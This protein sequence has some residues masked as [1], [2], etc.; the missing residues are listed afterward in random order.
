ME[1]EIEDNKFFAAIGYLG[2]LCL[3]PLLLAKDSKF[4]QHHGKQG[5]VILLAWILL[6]VGNIIPVLG[7]I[8]WALGSIL[9]FMLIIMGI[10]NAANGK[11]WELPVLGKFAK[12]IN[13]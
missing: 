10:V 6:W 2:I 7:Q 3:I 13:L 4:A 5:L 12:Q 8:V 9:L 11:M 1:K